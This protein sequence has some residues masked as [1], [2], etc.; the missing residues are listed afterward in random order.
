V[1]RTIRSI[2]SVLDAVALGGRF[3]FHVTISPLEGELNT[4]N[5]RLGPN[6]ARLVFTLE[7][8][9]RI[10]FT[11][12]DAQAVLA[13]SNKSVYRVLDRL[14]AK[15]RIRQVRKGLYLLS[16]AKSGIEGTWTEHVFTILT[17]LLGNDYYV[18]FW[19]ALGYWG[20]TEQLPQTTYVTVMKR[21]RN[22]TFDNQ[23]IQFVTYPRGRF[24]DYTQEKVGE[25]E[26]NISGREKTI[27]DSLA[28]L[29][30]SGGISE[31]AKAI[32]TA[33]DE[34]DTVRMIDDAEKMR[35]L[36]VN[37]R[38]GY[39]LE[40]LDFDREVY[41]SLL[42]RKPTGAPWLDPSATKKAVGYSNRWGLKLNVPRNVILH[43]K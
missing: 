5:I 16:P 36:A 21:V 39:L 38:L 4:Q 42:P 3:I 35:I 26:F 17:G 10:L 30:Y 7:R 34:M 25:A 31:V 19:S 12:K 41:S 13:T 20:M 9:G 27:V 2:G 18:G 33:R 37:L 11:S 43:W 14:K 23:R 8:D 32:W 29:Q 24:F 1:G 22:L 40:L 6:E 15:R 28:H